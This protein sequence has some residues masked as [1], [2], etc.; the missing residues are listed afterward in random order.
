MPPEFSYQQKRKL[1]TDAKLYIWDDPM[2]FRR[3]VDQIIRRCVLEAEQAGIMDK[4]HSSPYGGHFAEDI[5][6]Q[7]IL[8]SGFYWPTLFKYY[9]E[10]VKHYDRCQRMGNINIRN[11]MP[12]QGIMVV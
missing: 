4:F 9:F 5:T 1:R 6:T 7:K 12:L 8:Q 2:L 10:W 11:E 3:G